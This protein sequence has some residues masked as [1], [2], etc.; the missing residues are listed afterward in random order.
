MCDNEAAV[1]VAKQKPTDIIFRKTE[2]EFDLI[3]TLQYL[4]DDWCSDISNSFHWV[5]GHA[6]RENRP[7]LKHECLN[8]VADLTADEVQLPSNPTAATGKSRR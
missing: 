3:A 1:K 5:K 7:L 2:G 8:I 4:R 6:D